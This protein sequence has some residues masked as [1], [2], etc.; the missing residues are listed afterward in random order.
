M[1]VLKAATYNGAYVIGRTDLLGSLSSGKL[2]DFV[3]LDKNPLED[4]WNV[5]F[6]HSVVK[7]GVEYEPDKLLEPFLGKIQ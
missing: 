4:I 5:K 2:A 6:V 1:E 7:G 3:V